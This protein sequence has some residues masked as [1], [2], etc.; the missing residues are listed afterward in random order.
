MFFSFILNL[1]FK[2]VYL[3]ATIYLSGCSSIDI[4]ESQGVDVRVALAATPKVSQ[5]CYKELDQNLRDTSSLNGGDYIILPHAMKP[6]CVTKYKDAY[7]IG[8]QRAAGSKEVLGEDPNQR[9]GGVDD[10]LDTGPLQTTA[11]PAQPTQKVPVKSPAN[12]PQGTYFQT[13]SSGPGHSSSFSFA[14]SSS[15]PKPGMLLHL[16]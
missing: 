16:F 5:D 3:T 15:A 9:F 2:T 7:S 11:K 13:S 10:R 4:G 6:Q 12:K 14:Q 1:E 8:S